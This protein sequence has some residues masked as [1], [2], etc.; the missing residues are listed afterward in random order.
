LPAIGNSPRF[1]WVRLHGT[2]S[3]STWKSNQQVASIKRSGARLFGT[4]TYKVRPIRFHV[5]RHKQNFE[6]V[7]HLL[8]EAFSIT[9]TYRH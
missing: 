4:M 5:I 1:Y 8:L 2:L 9:R 7:L 3:R 6:T